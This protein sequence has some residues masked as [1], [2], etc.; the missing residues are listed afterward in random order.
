MMVIN[1]RAFKKFRKWIIMFVIIGIGAVFIYTHPTYFAKRDYNRAM[2]VTTP[3]IVSMYEQP[4]TAPVAGLDFFVE[5]RVERDRLR[6]ERID[7]LKD[8]ARNDKDEPHQKIQDAMIKITVEKQKELE[9]ENL[10]KAKGFADAIVFLHENSVNVVVKANSL[11]KEEVIQIA[12]LIGRSTAIS[13]E[14]ITISAKQ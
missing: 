6:S 4:P 13:P 8:V 2:S 1:L 11:S 14:H 5:Y 12:E 7:L 3:V 10:I 9:T